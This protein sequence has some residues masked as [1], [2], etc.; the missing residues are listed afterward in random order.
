[1]QLI[2]GILTF[3]RVDADKERV[4]IQPVDLCDVVRDTAALVEPLARSKGLEFRTLLL[5]ESCIVK[6]DAVRCGRS[7]SICCPTDLKFT[8]SGR[9]E[10]ELRAGE[11]RVDIIVRDTGPGIPPEQRDIIFE[12]FRQVGKGY[13][14]KAAG[15]GLGLSVSRQLARLLGGD[16]SVESTADVGSSFVVTLPVAR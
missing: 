9:E 11:D 10:A 3:A 2:E 16:V 1:M 14:G 5:A 13:T 7:Y 6:T 8:E 15:T 4:D 12:P